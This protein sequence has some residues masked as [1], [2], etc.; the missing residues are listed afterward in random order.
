MD[1]VK[2]QDPNDPNCG[3][4]KKC[5]SWIKV[6]QDEMNE[7]LREANRENFR[8]CDS[9][10]FGETELGHLMTLPKVCAEII[11]GTFNIE[12]HTDNHLVQE[13][14]RSMRH[15]Q[16]AVWLSLYRLI[17]QRPMT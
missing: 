17:L 13:I 8:Q 6:D 1:K 2:V 10:P 15:P 12:K 9:T 3:N 7:K 4:A 11:N 16:Q 5:K 14:L